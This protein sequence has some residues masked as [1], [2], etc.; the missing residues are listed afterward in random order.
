MAYL[1]WKLY[2]AAL[3]RMRVLKSLGAHGYIGS[4]TCV[5]PDILSPATFR[6]IV[7]PALKLFYESIAQ[8]GLIPVTYFLG[9]LLPII[10]DI[11]ASGAR[12]L[13]IEEPK[14]GFRL[15]VG[16]V[17]AALDDRMALFGNLDSVYHLLWGDAQTVRAETLRQVA[18]VNGG[19]TG[20]LPPGFIMACGSPLCMNTPPENILAM[21]ETARELR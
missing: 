18:R 13:M 10:D 20:S 15:E 8:I 11:A 12:A 16:E 21:L 2:E 17:Y 7:F 1:L 9:D 14:K 3:G 6:A 5:S 19:R 4:E